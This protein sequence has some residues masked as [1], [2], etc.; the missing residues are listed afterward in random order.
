MKKSAIVST[1]KKSLS[2]ITILLIAATNFIGCF[3]ELP[4]EKPPIHINPNMDNQE[5]Y[6]PQGESAFFIDK[7]AM[8]MPVAGTVA[9]GELNENSAYYRGINALGDTI[10]TMPVAVTLPLL[11]RGQERFNIYCAP[12]H[13]TVGDGKGIVVAKGMLPPPS[14][15]TDL[16]RGYPDGHIYNVITNG[17]RNMPSYKHQI[18]VD[19][20]WAIVAYV[21]ALQRSQNAKLEDL[22][23]QIRADYE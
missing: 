12:C 10:A 16:L 11:Q 7:S 18:S 15:H 22:T 2:A 6:R 19:D 4:S 9:R 1:M 5:R 21:R 8:R 23:E 13:S 3:Q 14:F 20:R 17:I